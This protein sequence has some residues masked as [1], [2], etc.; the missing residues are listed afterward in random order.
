M[1]GFVEKGNADDSEIAIAAAEL[2]LEA[3]LG[4]V[5]YE[6]VLLLEEPG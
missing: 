1:S 4:L 5:G 6:K 3:A 2:L